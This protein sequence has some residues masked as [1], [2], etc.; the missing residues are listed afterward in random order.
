[1]DERNLFFGQKSC[2]RLYSASILALLQVN[3]LDCKRVRRWAAGVIVAFIL[4]FQCM[5]GQ[6]G[7]PIG[8]VRTSGSSYYCHYVCT[9]IYVELF[10][11]VNSGEGGTAL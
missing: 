7:L 9:S 5:P 10:I 8:A 4:L 2:Q 3:W 1:M 6:T 11:R